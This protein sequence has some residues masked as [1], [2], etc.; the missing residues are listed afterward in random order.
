MA[1]ILPGQSLSLSDVS[2]NP[3][4]SGAPDGG[5]VQEVASAD[6]DIADPAGPEASQEDPEQS[7]G[8]GISALAVAVSRR[9]GL[10][11]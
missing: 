3:S 7:V 10:S 2:G 11:G 5:G 6:G 4:W 8:A 1:V 9:R